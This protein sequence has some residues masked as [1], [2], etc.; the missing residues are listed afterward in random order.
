MSRFTVVLLRPDYLCDD[1][2]YGQDVYVALVEA[3][4]IYE[5]VMMARREVWENDREDGLEP[6]S[7]LDYAMCVAFEGHH[8][9]KLFGWQM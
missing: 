7:M 2:P 5:G 6:D 8:D 3:N 9:V 1:V 4:N